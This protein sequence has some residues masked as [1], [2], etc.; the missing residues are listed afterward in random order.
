MAETIKQA[1]AGTAHRLSSLSFWLIISGVILIC[2]L[3]GPFGTFEALP[4]SFRF[5]YWGL[6]II[7]TNLLG[8]WL[9]AFMRVKDWLRPVE[10]FIVGVVFG[11]LASGIVI[12][13][14]YA[15]LN[16]M[17]GYPGTLKLLAYCFPSAA[18]IFIATVYL[19]S[20]RKE[21][22]KPL[23]D[24]HPALFA[25]LKKYPNAQKVLSLNAQDHYVEV[26]TEFGSELC[27][28]RLSDAIAEVAPIEGIQIHRSSWIAKSAIQEIKVQGN[29]TEVHL[30]NG[31]TL[32]VSQS[33]VK[34]LRAFLHS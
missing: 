15:L 18:T 29:N 5:I 25:R 22:R 20:Q 14:S 19:D 16:P 11:F 7:I 3:S 1:F 21:D 17:N 6:I 23:L 30:I 31:N 24:Q 34:E 32:K 33:R 8:L 13:L 12:I 9:H 27:L 26:A 2:F 4:A 10:I 28:I